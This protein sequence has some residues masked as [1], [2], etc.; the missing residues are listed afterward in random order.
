MKQFKFFL[1]SEFD[2]EEE[3][4]REMHK[5]GY[6]FVSV[7]LPGIYTFKKCEP[8]DV[9]YRLDF[10]PLEFKDKIDYIQMFED[11]G[12]MYIQEM[13]EFS[14][15][16]KEASQLNEKE[17]EIFID[18]ESKLEMIKRISKRKLLPIIVIYFCCFLPN[19]NN[20]INFESSPLTYFIILLA[21]FIVYIIVR[22]LLGFQRLNNK[23]KM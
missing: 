12:W 9:V 20:I 6:E 10:N 11:Y 23:F 5:K 4:L 8:K 16:R 7:S 2:K 3:Y 19:M 17:N 21:I 22:V 14:Y 13:N 15:F 18:N 1:I